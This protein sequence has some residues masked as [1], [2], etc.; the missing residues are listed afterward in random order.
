MSGEKIA[1]QIKNK[2]YFSFPLLVSYFF[3]DNYLGHIS[4]WE[5]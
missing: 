2:F 4:I 1:S 3:I 5:T